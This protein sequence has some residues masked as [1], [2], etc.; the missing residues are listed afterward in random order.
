MQAQNYVSGNVVSE[1]YIVLRNVL[2]VNVKT[3]KKVLTNNEGSFKIEANAND[4]LRFI[5]EN[6]ERGS[7]VIK[8]SDFQTPLSIQLVQ[9]PIEIEKVEITTK[10]TGNLIKDSKSHNP[11]EKV[12]TLNNEI[13][14]YIKNPMTEIQPKNNIPS[15]FAPRDLYAG[16]INLLRISIM[17]G[18][19]SGL[20]K[21]L[22]DEAVKKDKRKPNFSKIQNSIQE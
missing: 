13:K 19:S 3:D 14:E 9:V 22:I 16:Q 2:I 12:V 21:L 7:K 15:S 20:V 18:S 4:E 11:S 10:L 8:N 17:G 5:K 1:N 6:Y